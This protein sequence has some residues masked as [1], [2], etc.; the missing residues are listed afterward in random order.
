MP[1]HLPSTLELP[2]AANMC[3]LSFRRTKGVSTGVT[4]MLKMDVVGRAGV[5]HTQ[6]PRTDTQAQSAVSSA[7]ETSQRYHCPEAA[8]PMVQEVPF[9]SPLPHGIS[10][11]RTKN[12]EYLHFH[13][14]S[15]EVFR[16]EGSVI[17]TDGQ[18]KVPVRT[19]NN[20][21]SF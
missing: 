1:V 6:P 4:W 15:L 7:G 9:T 2:E 14:M 8:S 20:K 12:E 19:P 17:D 11:K 10:K 13:E 21:S 18:S 5:L 16:T 3:P